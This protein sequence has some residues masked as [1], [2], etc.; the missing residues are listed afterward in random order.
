MIQIN[1]SSSK[2]IFEQIVHE[3]GK[4]IAYEI[5]KPN[6]KLPSVRSLAKDLGINPNTVMRAY[7]ECEKQNLVYAQPGKGFFVKKEDT[8]LNNLIEET[9]SELFKIINQLIKLGQTQEQITQYIQEVKIWF[10]L[11]TLVSH[12]ERKMY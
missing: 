3:I 8:G 6:D 11:K 1:H 12:S 10:H 2:P 7:D 5:L 4:L 9:Y